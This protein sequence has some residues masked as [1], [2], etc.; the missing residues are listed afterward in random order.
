V[1]MQL[2]YVRNGGKV[3]AYLV[4]GGSL[5]MGHGVHAL[6]DQALRQSAK[7]ASKQLLRVGDM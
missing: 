2:H 7:Q 3:L 4:A 1:T 6:L 5:C